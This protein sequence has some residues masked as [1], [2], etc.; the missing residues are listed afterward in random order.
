MRKII[1]IQGIL[2]GIT[3]IALIF[4]LITIAQEKNKNDYQKSFDEFNKSIKQDFDTFKSK[5]DSVFY[6]FLE[7]SWSTFEL[8]KDARPSMPKP[9]LQPVSDTASIRNIEITPIKR[10]TMLQDTGRQLILNGK[11]AVYQ[12]ISTYNKTH[13]TTT[14]FEH[15]NSCSE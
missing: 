2:R 8:F 11:P 10:R 9:V 7:Q 5:N 12:T 4:P 15:C 3:L 6:R 1:F 13:E 14:T